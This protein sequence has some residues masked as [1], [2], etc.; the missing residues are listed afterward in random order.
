MT[1]VSS[2]LAVFRTS[3]GNL[4]RFVDALP[5]V[6]GQAY[7][8]RAWVIS[9]GNQLDDRGFAGRAWRAQGSLPGVVGPAVGNG[10][11]RFATVDGTM[12]LTGPHAAVFRSRAGAQ[13]RF[14]DLG[15]A[16]C[17]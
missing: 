7:P 12:T 11:D 14:V 4:I 17:D 3:A 10:Q 13:V 2:H 8:F 15:L 9:N 5:G 6:I 1:L 16:T